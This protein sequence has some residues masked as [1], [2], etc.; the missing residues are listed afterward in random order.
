ME[1]VRECTRHPYRPRLGRVMKLP[2]TS[3]LA[4]QVPPVGLKEIDDV[5]DFHSHTNGRR[6]WKY[7]PKMS[8]GAF[9]RHGRFGATGGSDARQ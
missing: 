3:A 8:R 1:I 6:E 4:Y 9:D 7:R 2:V 5:P